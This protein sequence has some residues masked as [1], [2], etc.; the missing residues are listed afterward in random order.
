MKNNVEVKKVSVS[1]AEIF[2]ERPSQWGLRGDPY[3][4]DNLEKYFSSIYLPLTDEEFLRMFYTAFQNL[5]RRAF[6]TEELIHVQKYSHGGMSN[7]MVS[8]KFW[9]DIALPKLTERLSLI[10][11]DIVE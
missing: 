5:T 10:N 3:L 1:V 6:E 7:G 2:K 11:L 9:K 8:P 4:W